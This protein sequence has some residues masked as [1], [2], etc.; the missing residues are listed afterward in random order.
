MQVL[1]KENSMKSLSLNPICVAGLLAVLVM[2][3]PPLAQELSAAEEQKPDSS[4]YTRYTI[5]DLGVVGTNPNQPGQPFVISNNGWVSGGADVGAA[6]HAV[7]WRGGEMIDIGNPGLGG[8]SMAFGVNERGQAVGEAEDTATDLSTTEDF[9]GLRAMGYFSSPTPCVPFIWKQGKMVPLK[10]L[11][12]VNGVAIQINRFGGIAGYAENTTVDPG[13]SA[14]QIYQFKPV[15]WFRDRIQELPTKND[16]EG[17][18]FSINDWGQ[19]VGASGS[20]AP[21]NPIWLFN[22][23]PVHALLWQNGVA[24]DLGSLG[25]ASNNIAH[26]INNLGQVVGGSD[27]TGD[28]TTHAFLWTPQTRRMKDLGV[29]DDDFWSLALGINDEGQIVGASANADFSVLRAFVRR[30]GA[31]VDLNSLV[32]GTTALFLETACSI[33]SRGEIIGFA[34]DPNTGYIH[35][36]R[37]IPAR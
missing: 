8:N 12:G 24:I 14:P 5:Q 35:A 26:D 36:Y 4:R 32:A 13:C 16:K 2:S 37:A 33:N 19:V 23:S 1:N 3:V 21:F 31:L 25:G 7:L 27:L 17:V 20:C 29:V 30:N 18:A 10:T 28:Q 15:V 6:L 34:F 11:G 22:L 9:C